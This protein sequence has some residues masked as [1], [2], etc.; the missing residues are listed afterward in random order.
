MF[1]FWVKRFHETKV[2]RVGDTLAT[3]STHQRLAHLFS[4]FGRPETLININLFPEYCFCSIYYPSIETIQW[5]FYI[6]DLWHYM[7]RFVPVRI[8]SAIYY[9]DHT[10]KRFIKC[11]TKFGKY[12]NTN[13]SLLESSDCNTYCSRHKDFP[14]TLVTCKNVMVD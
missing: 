7:V 5:K 6:L 10:N 4:T 11:W 9:S 1:R 8:V 2:V 12:T 14:W 3:G 13:K